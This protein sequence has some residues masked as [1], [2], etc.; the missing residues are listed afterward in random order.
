MHLTYTVSVNKVHLTDTVPVNKMHLTDTV[1]VNMMHLTDTVP[2]NKMHL[3]GTLSFNKMYLIGTIPVNKVHL[4]ET[5]YLYEKYINGTIYH[6]N[7]M[8]P[9]PYSL[10]QFR[11]SSDNDISGQII[12]LLFSLSVSLALAPTCQPNRT[13]FDSQLGPRL[14]TALR[15][16]GDKDKIFQNQYST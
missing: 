12:S 2:F 4:T 10:S 1:S 8:S 11:Q 15:Y 13:V 5:V 16:L 9:R 6:R 14:L 3:P 7:D